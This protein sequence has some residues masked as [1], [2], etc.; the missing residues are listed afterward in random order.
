MKLC[1]IKK[2]M[3]SNHDDDEVGHN[4]EANRERN[5]ERKGKCNDPDTEQQIAA[6]VPDVRQMRPC[7]S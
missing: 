6:T 3:R 2:S 1:I 7:A 5:N 4:E